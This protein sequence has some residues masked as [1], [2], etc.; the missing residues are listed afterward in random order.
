M[1]IYS[2][3]GHYESDWFDINATFS[4]FLPPI[5]PE[6]R[7]KFRYRGYTPKNEPIFI[8][9]DQVEFKPTKEYRTI[10]MHPSKCK[11]KTWTLFLLQISRC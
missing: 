9:E 5:V 1:L 7:Y 10:G 3:K 4:R 8:F 11:W 2:L 6:G